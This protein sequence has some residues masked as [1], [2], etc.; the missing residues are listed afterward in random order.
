MISMS[1]RKSP[2]RTGG[3]KTAA[4]GGR[5]GDGKTVGR[6]PG[7]AAGAGRGGSRTVKVVPTPHSDSTWMSPPW[8]WMN[9]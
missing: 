6:G 5:G 2:S 9:P 3:K 4:G 8:S 7:Q 1:S